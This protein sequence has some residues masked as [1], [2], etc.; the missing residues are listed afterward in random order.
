MAFLDDRLWCHP[1]WVALSDRAHRVGIAAICYAHGF[2]TRGELNASALRTIGAT[3]DTTT[4]LV[5]VGLWERNADRNAV[6]IHDWNDYNDDERLDRKRELTRERVR[7]HRV[8]NA[9][10]ALHRHP[11][12][13]A[14]ALHRHPSNSVTPSVTPSVTS[15]ARATES[16]SELPPTPAERGLRNA[17]TNP[18]A[19]GTNPRALTDQVKADRRAAF[20]EAA[21]GALADYPSTISTETVHERLDELE[22]EHGLR[23]ADQERAR[24]VDDVLAR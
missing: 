20:L 12:N 18:R 15:R 14:D 19:Q 21:A 9:A 17:S 1:K 6:V 5:T 13:A 24:L 8:R 2:G 4:E 16:E 7:R 11:S 23:L 3:D 10:D 22:L